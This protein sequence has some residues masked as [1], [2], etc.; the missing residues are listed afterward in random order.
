MISVDVYLD[1][2]GT[3]QFDVDL[4][5]SSPRTFDAVVPGRRTEIDVII[6]D[7]LFRDRLTIASPIYLSSRLLGED[8]RSSAE[9]SAGIGLSGH[10]TKI[11]ERNYLA[12][13][14][15]IALSTD[16]DLMEKQKLFLT[17]AGIGIGA[18]CEETQKAVFFSG[19]SAFALGVGNVDV[20]IDHSLGEMAAGI[21]VAGG[22]VYLVERNF[23]GAISP[24]ALDGSS[25]GESARMLESFD[26][27]VSIGCDVPNLLYKVFSAGEAGFAIDA[28]PVD[29]DI[30]NSLGRG[31]MGLALGADIP[32]DGIVARKSDGAEMSV[33]LTVSADV[34]EETAIEPDGAVAFALVQ[35]VNIS[36]AKYRLLLDMDGDALSTYDGMDLS[37]VDY[38]SIT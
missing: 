13:D 16:A 9:F 14:G 37:D 29:F 3:R 17:V 19:E 20:A 21:A 10:L 6:E 25:T 32:E 26:G 2:L 15:G 36:S 12:L 8:I 7:L 1:G 31:S 18:E 35:S 34:T 23:E 28:A 30:W 4:S 27:R 38:I 24:V 5:G 22:A 33:A 11:A